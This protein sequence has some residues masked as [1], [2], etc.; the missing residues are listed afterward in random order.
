[1]G[2][3]MSLDIRDPGEHCDAVRRAFA[4]LAAADARFST[5]RQDSEVSAVNRGE[6]AETGFSDDLREVIAIGTRAA[7]CSDGA[8]RIRRP[9]GLYDLDGVVKGWAAA[10]A[11]EILKAA[12]LRDFCLNAGGDVVVAGS[13]GAEAPWHV[14]VRSPDDPG[15][16]LAVLA[17]TGGAVATSGAYERGQHIVDGRTGASATGVQ[18]VTVVADDLTT[19][20]VLATAAFALG[21]A[22]AEWALGHGA[23]GVLLLTDDGTLRAG[24]AV[25]FARPAG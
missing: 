12:E 14:G 16:M 13:P 23:R 4:A 24:G 22:G 5:Y 25:D 20:D 1:M 9:D 19:A 8:F 15:R 2:I 6:L 7:A 11:A 10:R 21:S 17:V 18:S 3:P